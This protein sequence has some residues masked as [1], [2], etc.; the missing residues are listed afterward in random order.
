MFV[1]L[2]PVSISDC[3]LSGLKCQLQPPFRKISVINVSM[4][5]K[6]KQHGSVVISHV[7]ILKAPSDG[8]VRLI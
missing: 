4:P 6:I 1:D 3:M 5:H 8:T 2:R 7:A